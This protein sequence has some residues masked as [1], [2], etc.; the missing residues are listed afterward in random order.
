MSTRTVAATT[1]AFLL[2]GASVVLAQTVGLTLRSG[3]PT[4]ANPKQGYRLSYPDAWRPDDGSLS[5]GETVLLFSAPED[6]YGWGG[7]P[8]PGAAQIVIKRE[9]SGTDP[10]TTLDELYR[11]GDKI[12]WQEQIRGER[13]E[14]IQ[15]SFNLGEDSQ[16]RPVNMT[17]VGYCL[18][19]DGALFLFHLLYRHDSIDDSKMEGLEKQLRELPLS[20]SL[21]SQ[22]QVTTT[23]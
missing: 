18:E 8:K 19:M 5:R 22:A 15:Y 1:F 4:L 16:K 12:R 13:A 21:V 3:D 9:P 6:Q 10:I 7:V 20:L 23:E 2:C 17:R 14:W 11:G